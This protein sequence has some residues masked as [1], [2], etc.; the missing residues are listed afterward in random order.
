MMKQGNENRRQSFV[1]SK[2]NREEQKGKKSPE[3][4][5]KEISSLIEKKDIIGV[6]K[7]LRQ[8]AAYGKEYY[9]FIFDTM[10]KM[11]EDSSKYIRGL[12]ILKVLGAPEFVDY[13]RSSNS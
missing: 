9:K 5:M 10:K 4:L 8:L 6:A 2:D 7:L 13:R 3:E 12:E 1:D 11:S